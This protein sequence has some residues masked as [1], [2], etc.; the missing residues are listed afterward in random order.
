MLTE[1]SLFSKGRSPFPICI[2][3][4][5]ICP[6]TEAQPVK[7]LVYFSQKNFL[8]F[9]NQIEWAYTSLTFR[10][11]MTNHFSHFCLLPL[12]VM[13]IYF[14]SL[15][16]ALLAAASDVKSRKITNRFIIRGYLIG[17]IYQIIQF[18]SKGDFTYV[19]DAFIG[20]LLPYCF[21]ILYLLNVIGAADIKLFSVIGMIIGTKRVLLLI[22]L[23]FVIAGCMGIIAISFFKKEKNYALPFAVAVFIS[24]ILVF[25]GDIV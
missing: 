16:V 13:K 8:V 20:F 12:E 21:I 6:F 15:T 14:I 25:V 23:S 19:K 17:L 11:H 7:G 9:T 10:K 18:I 5:K 3:C 2:I 4:T 24:L 22:V 1:D